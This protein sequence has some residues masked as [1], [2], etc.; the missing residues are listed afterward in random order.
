MEDFHIKFE[1]TRENRKMPETNQG[2]HLG[3]INRE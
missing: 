2:L 3:I 1:T